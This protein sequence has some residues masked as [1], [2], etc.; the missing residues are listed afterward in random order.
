MSRARAQKLYADE[1]IA[2]KEAAGEEL[3]VLEGEWE[4][5]MGDHPTIKSP[6]RMKTVN[7]QQVPMFPGE[8]MGGEWDWWF[9]LSE[10]ER[11]LLKRR[12]IVE[13]RK[14][15]KLSGDVGGARE[16][17][18]SGPED[19]AEAVRT[20]MNLGPLDDP[21]EEFMDLF[22]KL[23]DAKFRARKAA[24][25][26]E[27]FTDDTA[28]R[29]LDEDSDG[30]L[31]SLDY[32]LGEAAVHGKNVWDMDFDELLDELSSLESELKK[33]DGVVDDG[34]E[35][36]YPDEY[37]R[38]LAE[39]HEELWRPFA[40]LSFD[41]IEVKHG[42]LRVLA[43]RRKNLL[44]NQGKRR[45]FTAGTDSNVT[46]L[47]TIGSDGR[48]GVKDG[49]IPRPAKPQIPGDRPDLAASDGLF[50]EGPYAKR[51]NADGTSGAANE[52]FS[53]PGLGIP[54]VVPREM[55]IEGRRAVKGNPTLKAQA[56]A[57]PPKPI[58]ELNKQIRDEI[59][60]L[61]KVDEFFET[62]PMKIAQIQYI[63]NSRQLARRQYLDELETIVDPSVPGERLVMV[64]HGGVSEAVLQGSGEVKRVKMVM[65]GQEVW[66]HPELKPVIQRMDDQFFNPE[67]QGKFV[68]AF[69]DILGMWKG[70]ATVPIWF[71]VGFHA[72][73][74][75]GNVRLNAIEGVK[76]TAYREA[77]SAQRIIEKAVQRAKKS[78]LMD[79]SAIQ[80]IIKGG[81]SDGVKKSRLASA[82]DDGT[83]MDFEDALLEVAVEEGVDDELIGRILSA[84][85][86][87]VLNSGFFDADLRG[88]DFI[89]NLRGSD[90]QSIWEYIKAQLTNPRESIAIKQ[91]AAIGGMVENNARLA[92]YFSKLDEGLTVT[93]ATA[94]V[95]R[96]LFDYSELTDFEKNVMKRIVPF[97][98]FMRKNTPVQL[99]SLMTTPRKFLTERRILEGIAS[100]EQA[101]DRAIPDWALDGGM[102]PLP[103]FM[104]HFLGGGNAAVM[105]ALDLPTDA[106]FETIEPLMEFVAWV[107]PDAVIPEEFQASRKE[108]FS[109]IVG[110]PGG[111]VTEGV[112]L[113]L[114]EATETDLFTGA[115]L[116]N[117]GKRQL[118]ERWS[119]AV[120]LFSKGR[121]LLEGVFDVRRTDDPE[122]V[123]T[124][125]TIVKNI[126]G[127]NLAAVGPRRE[128]GEI[129]SRIDELDR[130]LRRAREKYD[131]PTITEMR[132]AGLLPDAG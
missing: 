20:G 47:R 131:M 88:R 109:G 43:T 118:F 90:R 16:S 14:R 49:P 5:I 19:I 115:P 124:V 117:Q 34:F 36:V 15:R 101:D 97:Y 119:N 58:N 127:A 80:D 7:G 37:S 96:T 31:R 78:S 110:L 26:S 55:T 70:L 106:A 10:K 11:R 86:E 21:M 125:L 6:P 40:D 76:P 4:R 64:N 130:V 30:V 72:R 74:M 12:G 77:L 61:S 71:G 99:A 53:G 50:P 85:R 62:D 103:G 65:D 8:T 39:R 112:K 108:F 104:A 84:R 67:V 29:L 113:F 93:D 73:N 42:R 98:T 59:P 92:H 66:V 3:Y 38:E 116:D 82:F 22:R 56:H 44:A 83:R 2:A 9:A 48:V 35:K 52:S 45:K 23:E 107:L 63:H 57:V 89:A 32:D 27:E 46:R 102:V 114:E 68:K 105:G 33:I 79:D 60:E 75:M 123:D 1:N 25:N 100:T 126:T 28:R 122:Y 128:R 13:T 81:G 120:P 18:A 95:K 121:A 111:G 132:A 54:D 129:L 94:S 87:G 17:V 51:V 41:Q 91:G 24:S 69:D